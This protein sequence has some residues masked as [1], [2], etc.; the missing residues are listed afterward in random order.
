[1]QHGRLS[2][3]KVNRILLCFCEVITAMATAKLVRVNRKTVNGYYN[4]IRKRI[5][6]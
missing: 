6:S 3:R 5:L 2:A 1:M 4:A